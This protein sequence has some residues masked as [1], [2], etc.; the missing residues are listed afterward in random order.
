MGCDLDRVAAYQAVP[1]PTAWRVTAGHP[2]RAPSSEGPH[3]LGP[4]DVDLLAPNVRSAA[5]VQGQLLTGL[6]GVELLRAH[7]EQRT[8]DARVAA[9]PDVVVLVDDAAEVG[10]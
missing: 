8:K 9:E 5:A 7:T 4:S 2:A 6:Q 10:D 1:A 3:H